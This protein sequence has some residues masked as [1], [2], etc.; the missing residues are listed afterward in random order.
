MERTPL[1]KVVGRQIP[2]S[3]VRWQAWGL[4][5]GLALL[6][7]C[8][9]DLDERCGG[10]EDCPSGERCDVAYRYCVPGAALDMAAPDM[11]TPDM[12]LEAEDAAPDA[13]IS[14]M[15]PDAELTAFPPPG[16]PG[17]PCEG[18]ADCPA[19]SVCQPELGI[20]Y[21]SCNDNPNI[22]GDYA[23]CRA[24]TSNGDARFCQARCDV[25]E[26]WSCW[27][28]WACEPTGA[29]SAGTCLPACWHPAFIGCAGADCGEDLSGFNRCDGESI[30]DPV[31]GRC[32]DQSAVARCPIPCQPG[33]QCTQIDG[34]A[35]CVRPDGACVTHYNCGDER[36]LCHQGQCVPTPGTIP[37]APG[38]DVC[39]EGTACGARSPE[40]Q[41]GRCLP[42]CARDEDC[43]LYSTCKTIYPDEPPVCVEAFCGAE[44]DNGEVFGTCAVSGEGAP[45]GTCVYVGLEDTGLCRGAGQAEQGQ[46][47][48][49]QAPMGSAL[50]CGPGLVC[51]ADADYGL[52]PRRPLAT[53]GRCLRYCD[54][55]LWAQGV[56]PC[57]DAD[58][59]C[60]P[61]EGRHSGANVSRGGACVLRTCTVGLDDVAT[62]ASCSGGWQCI[63][64]SLAAEAGACSP[65]GDL[66]P[67]TQPCNAN[68]D[69]SDG[70]ICL[71][72]GLGAPVCV[73]TCNLDSPVNSRPCP[74]GLR[75][76]R[77]SDHGFG[78]C[79]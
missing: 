5:L 4:A 62:A 50:S 2:R 22:C 20:C 54:T 28:G 15:A 24:F 9:V 68:L 72:I 36:P 1:E 48:D 77:D 8:V 44:E 6:G 11:A 58:E 45:D 17:G 67:Y 56:Q 27:S 30:C 51:V 19:G 71:E 78:L 16:I 70:A 32:V 21:L 40:N 10:D 61:L 75:C 57:P 29:G 53:L 13:E 79:Q 14:D 55:A 18:Q 41:D 69:C 76:Q 43:P 23:E 34:G 3:R 63:P 42:T 12:A 65:E 47:C 35:R 25:S 46:V 38:A 26:R 66:P 52:I 49:A 60:L 73:P 64:I 37:C 7:G 33:E 59:T 31:S 74:M 39:P